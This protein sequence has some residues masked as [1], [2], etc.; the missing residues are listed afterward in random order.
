MHAWV[1]TRDGCSWGVEHLGEAERDAGHVVRAP[2]SALLL[3]G[4][5]GQ[6]RAAA[7]LHA[8][9]W[10]LLQ[11]LLEDHRCSTLHISHRH[12]VPITWHS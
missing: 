9:M 2:G 12:R 7:A 4:Q 5:G 8:C 10:P 3:A 1:W 11:L 6:A